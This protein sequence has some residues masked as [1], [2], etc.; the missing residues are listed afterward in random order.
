MGKTHCHFQK[1]NLTEGRGVPR[2][3]F[4]PGNFQHLLRHMISYI[5]QVISLRVSSPKNYNT[6]SRLEGET[7]MKVKRLHHILKKTD[8]RI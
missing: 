6:V 3:Q 8:K 5:Y 4:L 7:S 1:A 2:F